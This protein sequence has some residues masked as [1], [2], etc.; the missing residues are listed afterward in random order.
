MLGPDLVAA[1]GTWETVYPDGVMT[2][3]GFWSTVERITDGV[4]QIVL[5]TV[6]AYGEMN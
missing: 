4:A 6:G 2:Q 3:N 5:H 1:Y